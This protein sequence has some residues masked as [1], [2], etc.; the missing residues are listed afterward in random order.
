MSPAQICT[1]FVTQLIILL[2]LALRTKKKNE[3]VSVRVCF[4][5]FFAVVGLKKLFDGDFGVC[6]LKRPQ[7]EIKYLC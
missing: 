1:V 2:N 3:N 6:G 4:F 5:F 7:I